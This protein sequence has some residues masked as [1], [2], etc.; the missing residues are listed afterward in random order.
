[1][2]SGVLPFLIRSG[3]RFFIWPIKDVTGKK[4]YVYKDIT[5]TY[6]M[7]KLKTIREVARTIILASYM[8]KIIG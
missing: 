3:R 5:S 6:N 4:E 7:Y 1:M 8:K 2:N